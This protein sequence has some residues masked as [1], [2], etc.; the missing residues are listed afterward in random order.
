[1][2]FYRADRKRV[3]L[4]PLKLERFSDHSAYGVGF[5]VPQREYGSRAAE[6]I[7]RAAHMIF[8]MT[9][10]IRGRRAMDT[11]VQPAVFEDSESGLLRMVYKEI[12][13][14]LRKGVS[15]KKRD[16]ILRKHGFAVRSKSRFVRNQFVTK[17]KSGR[18]M[19]TD[20]LDVANDW[21]EMDEVDFS[22]PNFVSEYHRTAK[23]SL[24]RINTEQWHLWNRGEYVGQ[25]TGEDV[26]AR[27]AWRKTLG[28][29]S[30]IVAV[31]DDGVDIDHP[32]LKYRIARNP[33]PND[34]NDLYG[35]D[36][37][38]PEN[39]PEHYNPRPKVFQYPYNRM[40]GNDIHG[41]PCA[42]V[43]AAAGKTAYVNGIA[44]KCTLLPVKIF[45]ADSLASDARV[46]DAIRY[47]ASVASVISCSWGGPPSP[48]VELA[49]QDAAAGRDGKGVPVFCAAGNG[50]TNA[51]DFPAAYTYAIAVGASTD[52][53]K[54][55]S[56]SNTGPEISMVAPSSGGVLGIFTTDLSIPNRGFNTGNDAAGGSNGLDT[57]D[58][59]GT[60]SATPLAAGVAALML[61]INK[62]LTRLELRQLLEQTA[63]K[64]GSGYDRHGHS[65]RFGY[66]R[67][68][69]EAAVQSALTT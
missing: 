21:A 40:R 8:E 28:R 56:Y 54:L 43:V 46:A 7:T 24:P 19:G 63:E 69:A 62:N 11:A 47:A 57:N 35:R 26:N 10:T 12:I 33:D 29:P 31:L 45:H 23:V 53:A 30:V 38:V 64:I 67:V 48:D 15:A 36:F 18:L 17:H 2:H 4:R 37:F 44:P 52:Q 13:I 34:P 66:G 51:V 6:Q 59:G 58:F 16:Q 61:S 5:G 39:H 41:T 50:G 22:A 25:I 65:R 14:R 32:N 27:G 20:L 9:S 49:I 68:D 3:A 1:M 60:S 42:G 55:A